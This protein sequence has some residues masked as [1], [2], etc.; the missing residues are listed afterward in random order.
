MSAPFL[1]CSIGRYRW[2]GVDRRGWRDGGRAG[3]WFARGWLT[4]GS[5]V[6]AA[7]ALLVDLGVVP[8]GGAVTSCGGLTVLKQVGRMDWSPV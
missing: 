7:R 4:P 8:T 3:C 2:P 5:V 1:R 6:T